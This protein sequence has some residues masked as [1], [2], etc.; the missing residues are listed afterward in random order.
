MCSHS[1]IPSILWNPKV[2]YRVHK[3]SPPLPILSQTNPIHTTQSYL[4]KIHLMLSIHPSLGLP[5]DLFPSG[6][7][8]NYLYTFLFSPIRATCSAHL[9]LLDLIILIILSKEYQ[10][11]SSSLCSF[12][13]LPIA[14]SSAACSQAPSVHVENDYHLVY[15]L[16][17]VKAKLFLLEISFVLC[18]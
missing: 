7:P 12:V 16:E 17:F 5:R 8:A 9:I 4:Y 1:V 18:H 14:P 3:S 10:S 6:F 2:H 13:H 15:N 11:C